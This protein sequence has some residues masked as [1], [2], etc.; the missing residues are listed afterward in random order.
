MEKHM[1]GLILKSCIVGY[2]NIQIFS[3][4][5]NFY[6]QNQTITYKKTQKMLPNILKNIY[7][8]STHKAKSNGEF[9]RIHR[10]P[11]PFKFNSTWVVLLQN[12][13]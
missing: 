5:L 7:L 8:G 1:I 11:R 6:E 13:L 3:V 12:D 10:S 2:F 4:F 9:L